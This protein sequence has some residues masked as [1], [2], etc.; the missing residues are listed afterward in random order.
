MNNARNTQ[1]VLPEGAAR[2]VEPAL[3]A[4]ILVHER[5]LLLQ[6]RNAPRKLPLGNA[7]Q[8]GDGFKSLDPTD[9]LAGLDRGAG[10]QFKPVV[11]H[12]AEH[13]S[14][15]FRQA[16]APK[17]LVVPGHPGMGWAVKIILRQARGKIR[18]LVKHGVGRLWWHARPQET[19]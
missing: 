10:F 4:R 5:D 14:G 2:Q 7:K 16:D 1:G 11:H 17:L 13:A 18:A 3:A 6:H 12:L 9:D 19:R 8:V 15:E